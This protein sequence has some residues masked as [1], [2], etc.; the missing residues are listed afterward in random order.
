[1]L[2]MAYGWKSIFGGEETERECERESSVKVLWRLS[3]GR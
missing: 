3:A 2:L 1:M